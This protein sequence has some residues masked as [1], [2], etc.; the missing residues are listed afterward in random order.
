M[1]DKQVK[2]YVE[3]H[4]P[5]V[6]KWVVEMEDQAKK[7]H[8]PI[9]DPIGMNFLLQ[10][11]RLNK[12]QQILEIG[13]AIGYSALRMLE[14]NPNG[15]IVTIERDDV[16]YNQAIE[17]INRQKKHNSIKVIHGDALEEIS[18]LNENG[19]RFDCIFIDAAKGQYQ[20][21]FELASPLLTNNGFIVTD[22]VLFR[23]YVAEDNFEH[24]RYKKMVEKIKTFN[25]WLHNHPDYVTTI[26]PIGDGVAVSYKK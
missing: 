12:P 23:G 7:G 11:I 8:I 1:I 13:T 18:K 19:D 20:R 3:S 9:M 21:F 5:I 25:N 14:A 24:P 22:N 10:L 2:T 4:L 6:D 26:F 17:N 16:R 15:Q